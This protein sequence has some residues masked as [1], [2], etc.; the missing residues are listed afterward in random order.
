VTA[1]PTIPLVGEIELIVGA[2][3]TTTNEP[4]LVPVPPEAVTVMGPLVTEGGAVVVIWVVEFTVKLAVTPLNLT[5]VTP[6]KPVPVNTTEVPGGPL[7]GE[8]ETIVTP[9]PGLMKL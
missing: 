4:P 7:A 8:N 5:E 9:V 6:L 2:G 3:D 1:D